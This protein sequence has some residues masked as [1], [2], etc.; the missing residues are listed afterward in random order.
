VQVAHKSLQTW[1]IYEVKLRKN[2]SGQVKTH[3]ELNRAEL[4]GQERQE[5]SVLSKQVTQEE[6]QERQVLFCLKGKVDSKEQ[7]YWQE[8]EGDYWDL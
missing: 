1:Q 6:W 7:V 3:I 2:P 8:K 4:E 5:D